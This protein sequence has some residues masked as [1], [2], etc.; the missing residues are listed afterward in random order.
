MTKINWFG[1]WWN[2]NESRKNQTAFGAL[3]QKGSSSE[4][5][6]DILNRW[7][8]SCLVLHFIVCSW[9][10][11]CFYFFVFKSTS[12]SIYDSVSQRFLILTFGSDHLLTG[13]N[14]SSADVFEHLF[15]S[16]SISSLFNILLQCCLQKGKEILVQTSN[17]RQACHRIL[18]YQ[19][20]T[21]YFW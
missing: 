3:F 9:T 1:I 5:F 8:S 6:Q 20:Y 16:V 19:C 4:Y 7:S 21:Y 17:R 18:N 13:I 15:I 10:S 14:I 12:W 11:S 2:Q